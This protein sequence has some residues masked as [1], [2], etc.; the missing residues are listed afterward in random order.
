MTVKA[1]DVEE[2][3]RLS[4]ELGLGL[5]DTEIGDYARAV[6]GLA[7]AYERVSDPGRETRGSRRHG[8]AA[9]A[10][11]EPLEGLGVEGR[12]LPGEPAGRSPASG[13]RSR[14]TS[15]S[16]GCRCRMARICSSTTSPTSTPRWWSEFST[17]LVRSSARR[18]ARI[19]ASRAAAHTCATGPILNPWNTRRSAGGSS[20]GS[21]ALVAAGE[22]D[23][24][25]GG[26]QGGSIRIPA[27]FS[28]IVGHKPT[29]G[30]V[31]YYGGVSHRDDA[32][33]SRPDG[34][35]GRRCRSFARGHRR[36]RRPRSASAS[37]G[38]QRA[39]FA[40]WLEARGET[41]RIGVLQ[42]GFGWPEESE[43]E[44]DD[45]VRDAAAK[46]DAEERR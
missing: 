18:P 4:Q 31:P 35:N 22:V 28:G 33:S 10:S 41:L 36:R 29:H 30:L 43:P 26:D 5:S 11:G 2:L 19:S 34:G 20:G 14:T 17:Q 12:D 3:K 9:G 8:P 15:R 40:R 6:V 44:V 16:R 42:E 46:L 39:V 7:E 23:L 1:P 37:R 38:P 27:S 21:A 13:S 25:V 32:R 45:A 24:A